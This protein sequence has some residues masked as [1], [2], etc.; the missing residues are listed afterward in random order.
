M[1]AVKISASEVNKLRKM[2]GA[3]MMDCKKAL[4]EAG[5][6]FEAA[7][8]YLRKKGQK[9]AAKRADRDTTEGVT[10]AR[11]SADKTKAIIS[12]L[13][14]ETDFVAKNEDFVAFATEIADIAMANCPADKAA[15]MA[16]P[17]ANGASIADNI[18]E[19][20]GKIGEKLDIVEYAL[21]EGASVVSYIHSNKKIGVLVAMNQASTDEIVAAGRDVAMQCAAMRPVALDETSVPQSVIDKELE[22]GMEQARQ[23]GKPENMLERIAQGKLKRY[24]KDNTLVNQ[25]FVKNNKQTVKEYLNSVSS[26]L[27]ATGFKIVNI[28]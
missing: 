9:V 19:Q 5:G 20:V 18:T 7:I 22:I 23:E 16:L 25:A 3:G 26:G 2:T 4:V 21:V 1:S 17:M 12:A 10:I 28:G 24:F 14:C 11:V 27:A 13:G 15:L 6:D 8:E